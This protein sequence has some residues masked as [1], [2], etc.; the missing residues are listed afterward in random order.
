M[1]KRWFGSMGAL[2]MLAV[3]PQAAGA[4]A[5]TL[6]NT[7]AL[8]AALSAS[9]SNFH[10]QGMGFDEAANELI[11]AQQSGNSIVRTNLTGTVLGTRTIGAIP[12]TASNTAG[13]A[14]HVVSV[15]ADAGNYYFSDYTSNSG[16]RDLYKLGKTTGAATAVGN[17]TAAYGGYPIDVRAGQL[18]RTE[19]TT[20][21]TNNTLHNIRVSSTA[22]PDTITKTLTL[23]GAGIADFAVD[24]SHNSIWVLDY[25]ASAS[26]RRFDLD[27]GSL[28]E[29][30]G[31]G[32]EGLDAGLTYG[33]GQ[34]F[35]YD[36][37]SGSGSSLKVFDISGIA[38][39]APGA[40]PEPG[41]LALLT[42]ALLA[43]GAAG[44]RRT[45][46]DQAL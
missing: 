12:F 29:T 4:G 21:Y 25:L 24:T 46:G 33:N 28:L 44:R 23:A 8:G 20:G 14:N 30:F 17:E 27:T 34:L 10:P 15:A 3:L 40:L 26:I 37:R 32:L 2:A 22:T 43:M 35:Y 1:L 19:A 41:A 18:Y 7:Y 31:L 39:T 36:W 38:S 6:S 42:V 9:S 11:F 5:L 13:T 45:R 16:G